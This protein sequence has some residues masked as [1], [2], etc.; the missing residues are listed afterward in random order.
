MGLRRDIKKLI[1]LVFRD[2]NNHIVIWQTPN[3]P[4]IGWFV[5]MLIAH[6]LS[7][8]HLKTSFELISKAFL[9]AWAYLE[10]FQGVN[11]F[12]RL[13]GLVVLL[14]TILLTVLH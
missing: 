1:N 8:G 2:K 6:L 14:G 4:I 7:D 12:R 5:F 10:L 3:I 9:L 13:L 11:Y